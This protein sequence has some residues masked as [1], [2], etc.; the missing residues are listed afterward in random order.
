MVRIIGRKL[1][2]ILLVG[3][4]V[5][6]TQ[7]AMTLRLVD[8]EGSP[9]SQASAGQPFVIELLVTD[10]SRV[11]Q[12][13][14]IRGLEQFG[15]QHVGVAISTINGKTTTKY[16][17]RI[18]IDT[19]GTYEIG[20]AV[21]ADNRQQQTSNTL[22]VVV[23]DH[24]IEQKQ[25]GK[26]KDQKKSP[27]LLRMKTDKQ[28]VVIGER[29]ASSIRFYYTDNTV[30]LKQFIEQEMKHLDRKQV[31]GPY[32]GVEK[33]DGVE[34]HYLEWLWNTY[35]RTVGKQV[36]PAY[37]A[38]YE[39]H[40]QRDDLWGG[41]GRYFGNRV[42]TKRVYSNAVPLEVEAL[43]KHTKKVDAVGSFSSFRMNAQPVVAK[44]GEGIVLT[45]EL[46]GD[47]DPDGIAISTLQHIPASLKWYES[48]KSVDEPAPGDNEYTMRFEFVVQGLK[49]GSW[50]IPA[51]AFHYYDVNRHEFR[52]L[53]SA[54]LTVTIVPGAPK[55]PT[56]PASS[57]REDKEVSQERYPIRDLHQCNGCEVAGC[58]WALPWWLVL[59][60]AIAPLMAGIVQRIIWYLG[61][62]CA[63]R[64]AK[65]RI[66]YAFSRALKRAGQA[67]TAHNTQILYS[68]MVELIS[69]RCN[70]TAAS[71]T[72][73]FIRKRLFDAGASDEIITQ[74]SAFFERITQRAY[75]HGTAEGDE[76]LGKETEQWIKKLQDYI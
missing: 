52:T 7:A 48:K 3:L 21:M 57:D 1:L 51:Q 59:L 49:A 63:A 13:P 6:T 37:G 73:D 62:W 20:P 70:V 35:P 69:A 34:Y 12:P 28:K 45:M 23:G 74:W 33:I 71:V 58:S 47:G 31:R 76:Q 27:V 30:S 22:R 4:G 15:S 25:S 60:L 2:L 8:S 42:E 38:D 24:A 67:R 16:S 39:V 61:I 68:I 29:I 17:Y 46:V 56:P 18:R 64:N 65:Q 44:Q 32:T 54:P 40:M 72:A 19:P 41:L 5:A 14:T 26:K 53:K 11:G 75:G 36:I 50:E 10:I 55:K 43:P 66:R 9:L